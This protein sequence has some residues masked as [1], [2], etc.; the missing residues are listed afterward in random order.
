M[1][2][3][4]H[5]FAQCAMRLTKPETLLDQRKVYLRTLKEGGASDKE[6]TGQYRR[7][8]NHG[9]NPG[10]RKIPWRRALPGESHGQRSLLD[11][12]DHSISESDITEGNSHACKENGGSCSRKCQTLQRDSGSISKD[13]VMEGWLRICDLLV[14]NS[15]I[16]WCWA[17]RAVDIINPY[18]LVCQGLHAH[19]HQEDTF[20]NLVVVLE[21]ENS[22]NMN[23]IL[24]SKYLRNIAKDMA[25]EVESV[26][27]KPPMVRLQMQQ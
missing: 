6:P 15:L 20:F 10:V 19:Y 8:K 26:P 21:C 24:L 16:G 18:L 2:I 1:L 27:G 22:E 17:E 23:E 3:N 13:Q 7:H 5:L 11:Y 14:H 12:T 4:P 25:G 9:F